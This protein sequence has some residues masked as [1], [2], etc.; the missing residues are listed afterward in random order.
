MHFPHMHMCVAKTEDWAYI[1]IL[2]RILNC[3]QLYSFFLQ[4]I[5]GNF[6]P[7]EFGSLCG[8]WLQLGALR[9]GVLK[10]C[11]FSSTC[12]HSAS[13]SLSVECGA[14]TIGIAP[15]SFG[16]VVHVLLNFGHALLNKWTCLLSLGR[17]KICRFPKSICIASC[18]I[19][20]VTRLYSHYMSA[21]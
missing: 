2:L 15:L 18:A 11:I 19:N 3:A 10:F 13:W 6:G 4:H 9:L 17:K 20:R 8:R 5:K 21:R 7:L 1:L 16:T 14:G 12:V